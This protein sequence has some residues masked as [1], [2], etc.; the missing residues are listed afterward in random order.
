MGKTKARGIV[1]A[2]AVLAVVGCERESSGDG[3]MTTAV[4]YSGYLEGVNN[5][6]IWGWAWDKNHPDVQVSVDIRDGNSLIATVK[7]DKSRPDLARAN[8]GTGNHAFVFPTPARLKDGQFHAVRARV[9]GTNSELHK[10]PI[11]FPSSTT[12]Q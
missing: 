3:A 9:S 7:A 2:L 1:A 6:Q 11:T 12:I 10:S 8:I 4:H 5:S